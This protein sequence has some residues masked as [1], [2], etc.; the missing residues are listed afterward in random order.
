MLKYRRRD[1][2]GVIV[3]V[4][5]LA[6]CGARADIV[7]SGAWGPN[8]DIGFQHSPPS[9]S[10]AFG[11]SNGLGAAGQGVIAQMDGFVNVPGV[12]LNTDQTPD[13]G[14]GISRQLTNGPPPGVGFTFTPT[15]LGPQELQ[16]DYKFVNNTASVFHNFQF[17]YYLDGQIGDSSTYP[18]DEYAT[19][20]GARA[21]NPRSFQ[22][23]D[24]VLSSIFYN[25]LHGTLSN[26]NEQPVTNPGE[27]S[28]ALGFNLGD[29]AVGQ[30]AEIKILVSDDGTF[31]GPFSVTEHN[32]TIPLDTLTIS[33][34]AITPEPSILLLGAI[35]LVGMSVVRRR[36]RARNEP[37]S[38]VKASQ[39]AASMS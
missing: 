16:L 23:G 4:A 11:L 33:G 39:S 13:P 20:L 35:G 34:T 25:L 28:M 31:V 36:I 26:V 15:L 22:V 10:V 30:A 6:P 24:P 37:P 9:L 29:L 27:E 32:Q 5:A 12:D 38:T 21:G 19:T 1:M 18:Y 17:L 3:L 7:V 2:L 8:G 14:P